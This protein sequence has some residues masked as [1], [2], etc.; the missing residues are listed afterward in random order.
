MKNLGLILGLSLSLFA[1][2]V[3]ADENGNK[4]EMSSSAMENCSSANRLRIEG[5][6]RL[7]SACQLLMDAIWTYRAN[8]ASRNEYSDANTQILG[9]HA[10]RGAENGSAKEAIG[11]AGNLSAKAAEV[12]ATIKKSIKDDYDDVTKALSF[13][14]NVMN[15]KPTQ[16]HLQ[17]IEANIELYKRAREELK[18][19]HEYVFTLRLA[20]LQEGQAAQI[21]EQSLHNIGNLNAAAMQDLE[22]LE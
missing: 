12:Q 15:E 7:F 5:Y 16:V 19:A 21:A 13:S 4:E 10:I 9:A 14:L 2:P 18:L 17:I 8:K 22:S 11:S 20:L 6:G 1:T 3:F